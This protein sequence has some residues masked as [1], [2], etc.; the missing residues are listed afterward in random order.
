MNTYLSISNID[1]D[2]PEDELLPRGLTVKF[3]EE[4]IAEIEKDDSIIADKLSDFYGWCINSL[5]WQKEDEDACI[6]PG[7]DLSS[8]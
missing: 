5:T 4:D 2:A 8:C 3:S 1:W 7:I 6:L